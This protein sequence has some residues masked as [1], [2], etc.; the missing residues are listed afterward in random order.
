MPAATSAKIMQIAQSA[1]PKNG[2]QK[3]VGDLSKVSLF[4]G[5]VLVGIYIAPEKTAGGILRPQS[6]IQEDRWQGVVGLV[7]KKGAM[8]F[9]DD[10]SAKFHGQDVSVGDW[11]TFR[12]GDAKRIQINGVDC[13]IIEDVVIDMVIESPDIVTHGK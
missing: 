4:S 1:D 13:R 9:V 7:L 5:R 12:P 6:N 10:E 11:V 3:A 2:I 8:A